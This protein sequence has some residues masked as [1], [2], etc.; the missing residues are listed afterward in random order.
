MAVATKLR[1]TIFLCWGGTIKLTK[2]PTDDVKFRHSTTTRTHSSLPRTLRHNCIFSP[3]AGVW[4]WRNT[5]NCKAINR[6]I[7]MKIIQSIFRE[8]KTHFPMIRKSELKIF[9]CVWRKLEF[10]GLMHDNRATS[11]SLDHFRACLCQICTQNYTRRCYLPV[12]QPELR[13]SHREFCASVCW[14]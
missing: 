14:C 3:T 11:R 10:Q 8:T 9:R 13:T 1:S 5:R 2:P 4:S 12:R 7:S 6:L